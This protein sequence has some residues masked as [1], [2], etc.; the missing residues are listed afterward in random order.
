MR[1]DRMGGLDQVSGCMATLGDDAAMWDAQLEEKT[2]APMAELL[3]A[4]EGAVAAGEADG[5]D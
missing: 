5:A 2:W 4:I 1:D 3:A